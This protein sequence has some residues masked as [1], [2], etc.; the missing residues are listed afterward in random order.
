MIT[1]RQGKSEKPAIEVNSSLTLKGKPDLYNVQSLSSAEMIEVEKFLF[2]KGKYDYTLSS[3]EIPATPVVELLGRQRSGQAGQEE[4]QQQFESWKNQDVRRDLNRYFYHTAAN[5]QYSIHVS[6]AQNRITYYFSGGLDQNQ[7]NLTGESFRRVSLRSQNTFKLTGKLQAGVSLNYVSSD[8]KEGNNKGYATTGIEQGYPLYPYA[9]LVDDSGKALPVY[10]DYRKVFIDSAGRGRFLDWTYKPYDE[11]NNEVHRNLNR[12]YTINTNLSYSLT[13]AL[14]MVLNYQYLGGQGNQTDHYKE[15]SFYARNMI[16]N[17]TQ[18][19]WTT[20]VLQYP[21]PLGGILDASNSALSSHQG[22]AQ[23]NYSNTWKA[24]HQLSALAGYEVRSVKNT[25]MKNRYYG[26]QPEYGTLFSQLDYTTDLKQYSSDYLT[27]KI[28]PGQSFSE[29][30]DHFMSWF[31]NAAYTYDDR[32]IFSGSIRRDEANLFG[33][34]SNQKGT[35]LWSAGAA[36]VI[37]REPFYESSA[38]PYLKLRMSYGLNGNISRLASAYTT[39]S[40]GTAYTTPFR[41]AVIQTPPNEN[42]RWEKVKT[43][44]LGLDFTLKN[45]V[46]SGSFEL[47]NKHSSDLLAQTP[48]DP[49]LG[50]NTVYANVAAMKARGADLQLSSRNTGGRLKWQGTLIMSYSKQKVT[51]YLMPASAST[52][53]Y[54]PATA[55]SPVTGRPLYNIYSFRWAGLDP[56]NGDPVGYFNGAKSKDY[57]A[58]YTQTPLDSLEYNG[59]VQP[60]W[61]GAFRHTV[62]FKNLSLSLNISYKLGNYFRATSVNYQEII[63]GWSGHH[64]YTRR[65]QNPGDESHTNVPSFIYPLSNT[66]RDNF[67]RYSD[68]LVQKAGNIRLEDVSLSYLLDKKSLKKLPVSS[69]RLYLYASELAVLWKANDLDIDPY[70]NNVPSAGRGFSFGATVK[71]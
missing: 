46:L 45:N 15:S 60:V 20:G 32:Y 6:G 49:T 29:Q 12:Q 51:D 11:I 36:W 43:T 14:S 17:F 16:N 5:Q 54:L 23:L 70:Y 24:I 37:S 61:Y 52:F 57:T 4:V 58:I 25:T 55:I 18:P 27:R 39:A 63:A 40:F 44:N 31:A 56:A 69:I 13:K 50:F 38:L 64:D 10:L 67:Y 2:S 28:E 21:V 30:T 71:F 33:V 53:T 62:S 66:N 47:Y 65:W 48:V 34:K 1:T 26:Y 22:R 7:T 42:L 35:P 3:L 19:N 9:D 8:T 59:P 41:R 68:A